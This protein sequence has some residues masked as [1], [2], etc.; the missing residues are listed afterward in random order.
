[1]IGGLIASLAMLGVWGHSDKV[2]TKTVPFAFEARMSPDSPLIGTKNTLFVAGWP[3]IVAIDAGT[4]KRLATMS[5]RDRI[6]LGAFES[7]YRNVRQA[8]F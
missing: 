6:A 4:G 1:M 8:Y 5:P 2:T 7:M 3:H